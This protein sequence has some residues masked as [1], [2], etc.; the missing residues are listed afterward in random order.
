[1]YLCVLLTLFMSGLFIYI[2]KYKH[3]LVMLLSLELVVLS[4]YML[5]LMYLSF[6]LYEYFLCMIFLC[7]S[8]C[9]SVLGLSLLV[10]IIRSHGSDMVLIYD[11][12]W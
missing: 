9:E 10:M 5:T 7:M 6:F 4:L 3:F 1:M 8:V 11:S 12:L 2:V